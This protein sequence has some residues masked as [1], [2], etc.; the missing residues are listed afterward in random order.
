M[1]LG[2]D[3]S[4]TKCSSSLTIRRWINIVLG[5]TMWKLFENSLTKHEIIKIFWTYLNVAS[6]RRKLNNNPTRQSIK[7]CQL[8]G[9]KRLYKQKLQCCSGIFFG[10]YIYIRG[11]CFTWNTNL[12]EIKNFFSWICNEW[13]VLKDYVHHC[14]SRIWHSLCNFSSKI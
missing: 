14:L 3:I 6:F 11:R 10:R 9:R 2:Y 8:F 12:I 7:V 13:I 4:W 1:I 5:H